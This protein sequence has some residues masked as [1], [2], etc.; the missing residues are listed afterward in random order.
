MKPN[1]TCPLLVPS[2]PKTPAIQEKKKMSFAWMILLLNLEI[3]YLCRPK[4]ASRWMIHTIRT[5]PSRQ[6]LHTCRQPIHFHAS[7][8]SAKPE[9][10][11][12]QAIRPSLDIIEWRLAPNPPL[13][14]II[15]MHC[16]G[17][18]TWTQTRS[19]HQTRVWRRLYQLRLHLECR[20]AY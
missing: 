9:L 7:R 15:C 4:K 1:T 19:G 13:Y 11:Q 10:K 5:C 20:C 3:R 8:K 2:P 14:Q 17:C 18:A 16:T 12:Q 6:W